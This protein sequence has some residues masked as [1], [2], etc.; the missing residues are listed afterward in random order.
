MVFGTIE[1]NTTALAPILVLRVQNL[2][3]MGQEEPH[4][5]HIRVGLNKAMI[6]A[7]KIVD[8]RY[9]GDPRLNLYFWSGIGGA[10]L[11]PFS[12]EEVR[13]P[14]PGLIDV[15]NPGP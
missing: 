7:P 1:Q 3:K 13:L 15:D 11:L 4:H 6:S 5:L 8:R 2:R 14:N 10:L 12:A 9:Q